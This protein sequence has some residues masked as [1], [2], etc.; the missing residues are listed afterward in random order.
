MNDDFDYSLFFATGFKQFLYKA[1]KEQGVSVSVLANASGVSRSYCGKLINPKM[2]PME[3]SMAKAYTICSALGYDLSKVIFALEKQAQP[4]ENRISDE[5]SEV[6]P[7]RRRA[8]AAAKKLPKTK[9][10]WVDPPEEEQWEQGEDRVR[11]LD[12]D[13]AMRIIATAPTKSK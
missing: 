7:R 5:A 12:L 6:K 8:R 3:I 10:I 4:P 1:M 2:E 9:T 11:N 13:E